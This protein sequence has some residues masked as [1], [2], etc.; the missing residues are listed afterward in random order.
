MTNSTD[1]KNPA[2]RPRGASAAGTAMRD[3]I[4]A[5]AARLFAQKTYG[6][7]GLSELLGEADY[8]KGSFYHYFAS[9][10]AL[11]LDLVRAT[12]ERD[13]AAISQL[14]AGCRTDP[15]L[16]VRRIF[17]AVRDRAEAGGIAQA[18]LIAKLTVEAPQ[19]S[20]E[21]S[22]AVS[23]VLDAWSRTIAGALDRAQ[24]RGQLPAEWTPASW[25]N[26]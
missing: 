24:A 2:G 13:G 25:P 7:V 11:A 23:D 3:H 6:W 4:L 1:A 21:L 9:K 12:G 5:V 20:E 19:T 8:P 22:V 10:E 17:E 26:S 18:C 14:L 16:G 15:L